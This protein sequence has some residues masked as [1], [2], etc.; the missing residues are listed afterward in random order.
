MQRKR[1]TSEKLEEGQ[2]RKRRLAG[3]I[4]TSTRVLV[5]TPYFEEGRKQ[6][7]TGQKANLERFR[8]G[9]GF[10]RASM[11]ERGLEMSGD[12]TKEWKC[13]DGMGYVVSFV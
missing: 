9:V 7:N 13:V 4:Y 2:G 12:G 11:T 5:C 6:T 1:Y 8:C 3:A 10:V